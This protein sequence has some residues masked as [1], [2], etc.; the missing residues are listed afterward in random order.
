MALWQR[1]RVTLTW[2]EGHELH[3]FEVTMR[4]QPFS[5]IINAW[6]AEG[7]EGAPD[8]DDMTPKERAERSRRNA[9]DFAEHI[10][11]WN[12]AEPEHDEAGH[13]TG[14]E[15]P[16]PVGVDALLGA[17]DNAMLAAMREA[18]NAATARVAP[19]LPQSSA[20]GPAASST[21]APM[22]PED[23]GPAQETLTPPS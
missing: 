16:V 1:G 10:V 11:S 2:P 4:R 8:W 13:E 23:W 7:D 6:L 3:G 14:E 18:Y 5:E 12:L 22:P 21:A 20:A 19:P 15:R 9:G 17:V